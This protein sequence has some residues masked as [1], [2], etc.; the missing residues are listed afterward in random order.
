MAKAI[1]AIDDD[2]AMLS[3]YQLVLGKFGAVK[4]ALNMK[5]A[6]AQLEGTD[7]I[8]LDFHL[9]NDEEKIQ[10]IVRELRLVAPILLCSGVQD[11]GVQAMGVKL[12]VAGYWNKSSDHEA[13]RT[14]VRKALGVAG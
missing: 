12:D 1:L 11:A 7:L 8:I 5:E 9:A 14:Q 2:Q 13:L 4:A 3:I 6:R 10:D